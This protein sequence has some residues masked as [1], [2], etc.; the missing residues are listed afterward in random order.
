VIAEILIVVPVLGRPK[1]AQPVAD[2]VRE[3]TTVPYRLVFCCNAEDNHQIAACLA[4][5]CDVQFFPPAPRPGDWAKKINTVYSRSTEPF[6]LC[7]ADDLVFHPGWDVAALRVAAEGWGVIGTNDLGNSAVMAGMHATHPLVSRHY[8]DCCGTADEC[9]KF[10]HEGYTHQLVDVELVETAKARGAW[11]FAADS[12]VEHR[13]P[14][15]RKGVD[16]ETYRLGRARY[17]QDQALYQ[18]RR[19]LWETIAA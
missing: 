3:N 16:D 10:L 1:A 5:G 7:A 2:S 18:Q 13:H 6:L 8:A 12:H 9:G 14:F 4:T 11:A 17:A 15:W 19:R